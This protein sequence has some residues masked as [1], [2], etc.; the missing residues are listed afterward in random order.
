MGNQISQDN[1]NINP[2]S[3]VIDYIATEYILTQNFKDMKMLTET[4]YC[5]DLVILTTDIIANSLNH[6]Q[7]KYLSHR[8]KNGVEKDE[9]NK[10]DVLYLHKGSLPKLD[11]KDVFNKK[12]MC[13][14]IA[15]FYVK[16]SHLF[17]AITTTI[18]PT[19]TYKNPQGEIKSLG[20]LEKSKLPEGVVTTLEK[21]NICSKR[22]NALINKHDY[23]VGPDT[24]IGIL[25][26]FCSMNYD[27]STKGDKRLGSEPGIPEFEQL[28]QDIYDY[29]RGVFNGMSPNMRKQYNSDLLTFYKEFTGNDKIKTVEKPSENGKTELVPEITRFSQIPLKSYHRSDGCKPDGYFTKEKTGTLKN[30]LFSDYA[31]HIKRM[32]INAE[33]NQNK[34]LIILDQIFSVSVNSESEEKKIL[35]NPTLTEDKLDNLINETRRIIIDLYISCEEDFVKGLKIFEAIV[36]KQLL[37]T[38]I[39]QMD[40]LE[41]IA[42][43]AI[44]APP[45]SHGVPRIPS[46]LSAP[47]DGALAA[48][49]R[50]RDDSANAAAN[51][52]RAHVEAETER[53]KA[54]AAAEAERL[55]AEAA[56]AEAE[57][58]KA[59]EEAE[60]LKAEVAAAEAERL[61]AE[62]AAAEAERLKAAEEAERLKAEAAA[63]E[64]ERLKTE[65]AAAEAERLKAAEEA[66]RLKAAE[67]AERVKAEAAAEEA[68]AEEAAAE[69]AERLKAEAAAAEIE[70]NNDPAAEHQIDASPDAAGNDPADPNADDNADA[71]L[72]ASDTPAALNA[73]TSPSAL[74]STGIPVALNSTAIPALLDSN[75]ITSKPF[76]INEMKPDGNCF[77]TAIETALKMDPESA[78]KRLTDNINHE[79]FQK[80]K[81][82]TERELSRLNEDHPD[83]SGVKNAK[84]LHEFKNYLLSS[85]HF[86]NS[87]DIL[88]LACILG[89]KILVYKL[90]TKTDRPNNSIYIGNHIYELHEPVNYNTIAYESSVVFGDCKD[91]NNRNIFLELRNN[92]HF[93]LIGKDDNYVFT[94][95]EVKKFG[96]NLDA[97]IGI[98]DQETRL[99][100]NKKTR[101]HKNKVNKKN[102]SKKNKNKSKNK[103]KNNKK[104]KKSKNKS[105]KNKK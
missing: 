17:A 16:I 6:E 90:N 9:M 41:N 45:I 5:D 98:D 81:D 91:T 37:D 21:I 76:I 35:I 43:E 74:N 89:I 75:E 78:R 19:Y 11:T 56:A 24:E 50:A 38:S 40:Q 53:L 2:L 7:V 14:G 100:G 92:N 93:N 32:L 15:K 46:A 66:E 36:G 61:K 69:E 80:Y 28:Y 48:V 39:S 26:D 58:L 13:V 55:K 96:I 65:A 60:R 84:T 102:K 1:Q 94:D 33:Y 99:G 67:E 52:R 12:R 23:E 73:N 70:R 87:I 82:F 27:S 64:A 29:E 30:K 18:N 22:I 47:G 68:A 44:G 54:A 42:N 88:N 3:K 79:N 8:I 103:S 83:R 10:D 85:N 63:A 97:I 51:E 59:A 4:K 104:N 31:N 86:A 72:D 101:K 20:L 77:F 105:K 25:P 62:A 71:A 95:E 57:R 49:A 34:L